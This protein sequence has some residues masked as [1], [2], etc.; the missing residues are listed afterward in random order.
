MIL[1][2]RIYFIEQTLEKK[3]AVKHNEDTG[4]NA[5]R[6]YWIKKFGYFW[7]MCTWFVSSKTWI[8]FCRTCT[9]R[10]S[11]ALE[12]KYRVAVKV[13]GH[14]L[15]STKCIGVVEGST[16]RQVAVV[17]VGSH[18]DLSLANSQTVI[19]KEVTVK[20][21][22]LQNV[23]L[24]GLE[25]SK[26]LLPPGVFVVADNRRFTQG[27]GATIHRDVGVWGWKEAGVKTAGPQVIQLQL[28][29]SCS[30]TAQ[31]QHE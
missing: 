15:C 4:M 17:S 25:I 30:Q 3:S 6:V 28:G 16:T 21:L 7:V 18:L 9:T 27:D 19:E 22:Q 10:T 8:M 23:V 11:R 29:F 5:Y 24:L 26:L 20:N 12:R 1:L 14:I 13:Q 31:D 2:G